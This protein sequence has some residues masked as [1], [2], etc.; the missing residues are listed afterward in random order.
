MIMNATEVINEIKTMPPQ[1]RVQVITF[2]HEIEAE[3]DVGYID[4]KRFE[5]LTDKVFDRH[6]RLM[7]ELAS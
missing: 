7:R 4:D 1:E 5:E 3:T 6:A 2:I